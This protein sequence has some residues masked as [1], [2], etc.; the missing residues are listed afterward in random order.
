[1]ARNTEKHDLEYVENKIQQWMKWIMAR[2]L[3]NVEKE[4]LTW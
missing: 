2:K 3:I 4:K 1:M